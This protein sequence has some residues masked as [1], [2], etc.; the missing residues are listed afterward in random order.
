MIIVGCDA[1]LTCTGVVIAAAHPD[2]VDIVA[3]ESIRTHERESDGTEPLAVRAD[4]V[5][6]AG[7]GFDDLL[8]RHLPADVTTSGLLLVVETRDFQTRTH[9]GG[10]A[11][12]RAWLL[13]Q[14][15]TTSRVYGAVVAGVAPG[16]LKVFATGAGRASKTEV[17]D[18][19]ERR[20][21][22]RT[23]NDDEADA[24]TLTAMGAAA[25]GMPMVDPE[26]YARALKAVRWPETP[27]TTRG[28]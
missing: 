28:T 17:R 27:A 16:S 24:L 10:H 22:V 26:P 25:V 19:V 9:Q 21:G 20:Y 11:F 1:S 12:D 2:G 5:L 23:A 15:I 4:R 3:V 7:R 8:E 14:L 6:S 18:A 13:G